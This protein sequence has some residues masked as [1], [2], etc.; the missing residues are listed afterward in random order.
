MFH[1]VARARGIASAL[2]L[3]FLPLSTLRAQ[4]ASDDPVASASDGFGLTLGLESIGMYNSGSVR[5]FNPQTAGNVRIDGLYFDQ[6][7]A[8]SNRVV[9]G[10]TIRIGVSEIGYAFPAPTGIVDYDLRHPGNGTPS[11]TI[12]ASAGP[13][14]ARGLSIDGSFPINSSELQ[15][16]MGASYQI[17]TQTPLGVANPGYTSTVANFGATPQ[18]KPNDRLMFRGI[19][20]WTQTTHAKTL[21][22]VFTA[23]DYLP[24]EAPRGYYGENWAEGKSLSENYGGIVTAQLSTPWSLAAG[25][26]RSI[27][28]NPISYADLYQNTQ[29]NGAA[30][31]FIV[32][33]PDQVTSSTSGEV[34]ITGH[35]GTGSWR[36]DIVL[37]ARGRDTLALYGGSDVI[38]VG[39]AVIDQGIQVREPAFSYSARTNDRT[40]L[41]SAGLA[42]RV[43]WQGHGDFAFGIQQ[44]SYDKNVTSPGLPE[45]RLTDRPLRAY[46][47]A[48]LPLNDQVTAY[49][50]YTQGLEDSGVAP[51]SAENRGTILPDARTWQ[52]DAGV[53]Y[54]LTPRVTLMAGIFEIEKPY[55]NF[56]TSNVDRALGLQRATG[57]EMSV[58]GEV[59]KNLNVAAGVLLGEVKIVGPNLSA[60]RVGSIAFGQPR[61]YSVINADYKFPR[62]PALSADIAIFHFGTAPASV[63]DVTQNPAQT[64][65]LVGGRYRF[66]ILGAP[67]TLRV[68]VQNLTNFYFWNMGYSPGFSQFPPRAFFGYLTA[69]F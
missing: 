57:L 31:Q 21:P 36:Q 4:H 48:A 6:Q 38:A 30:E 2:L 8:L 35:F 17:S 53:R 50:G 67:A 58:S 65:L 62:W 64:V 29:P 40:E 13:F 10:S 59:L 45:A 61:V 43:Q 49:A 47:T 14:Q 19:F 60:E 55:F 11:A 63:D 32:G 15:L 56:D 42:Y 52:V 25:L 23:G 7:G 37:L 69:D 27:A 66:T 22:I 51:S 46:G 26:F 20:D 44:E 33:N 5:G 54:L 39:P 18:W 16:P 24:P 34:R 3:V 12:V 41:W 68:Q 28:D 9:E 1:A